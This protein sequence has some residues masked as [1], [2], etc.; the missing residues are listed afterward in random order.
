MTQLTATIKKNQLPLL[1]DE[2]E[3]IFRQEWTLNLKPTLKLLTIRQTLLLIQL[4]AHSKHSYSTNILMLKM[5][6]TKLHI[7]TFRQVYFHAISLCQERDRIPKQAI[8]QELP[9]ALLLF[10]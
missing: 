3:N 10:E 8:S 1:L 6:R 4:N 9:L 5:T 2:Q 7:T